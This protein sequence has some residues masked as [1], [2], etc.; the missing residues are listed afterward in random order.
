MRA[1]PISLSCWCH[2]SR[3]SI[4]AFMKGRQKCC[5]SWSRC[6]TGSHLIHFPMLKTLSSGEFSCQSKRASFLVSHVCLLPTITQ[7]TRVYVLSKNSRLRCT[8]YK[9]Q[10]KGAPPVS[11]IGP[12]VPTL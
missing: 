1:V 4:T 8:G 6:G 12:S 7:G 11:S 2:A 9:A 10:P 3:D 5:R